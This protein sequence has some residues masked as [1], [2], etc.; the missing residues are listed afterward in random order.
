LQELND[1][2]SR[3]AG[4]ENLG[5]AA[6]LECLRLVVG[7]GSAD[8]HEHVV[9]ALAVQ[10][11]DHARHQCHMRTREDRESD[12]IGIL[13]NRRLDD[14]VGRLVQPRVDN[15]H[16]GIAQG[17]RNHLGAAIM[18]VQTGLGYDY[19]DRIG[20]ARQYRTGRLLRTRLLGGARPPEPL[21]AVLGRDAGED[22]EEIREP[23]EVDGNEGILRVLARRAKYFSLGATADRP[24]Q[25]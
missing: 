21:L 17:A 6:L 25:V 24:R 10:S 11:L 18:P 9:G 23:V 4:S 22:E 15:L 7:D 20:H 12:G 13:L 3:C 2:P 16:T 14:L 8:Q 1:R 5:D 19:A